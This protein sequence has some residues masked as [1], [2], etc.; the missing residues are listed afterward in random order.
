MDLPQGLFDGR[1]D[2]LCCIGGSRTLQRQSLQNVVGGGLQY[3]HGVTTW[4]APT[5]LYMYQEAI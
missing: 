4:L 5:S 2:P 1:L 3:R